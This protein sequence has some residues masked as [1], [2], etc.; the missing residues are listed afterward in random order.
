MLLTAVWNILSKP[1]PYSAKFL[2]EL[3]AVTD[4]VPVSFNKSTNDD[5]KE[6][7]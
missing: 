1:E 2:S 3:E 4:D 5:C 6:H 7:I